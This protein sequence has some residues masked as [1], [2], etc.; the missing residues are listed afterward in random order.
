MLNIF[1]K[2]HIKSNNL[3]EKVEDIKATKT[4]KLDEIVIQVSEDQF[5]QVCNIIPN[6][7]N[8]NKNRPPDS[9]RIADIKEYYIRENIA[10]IP[11]IIYAWEK[12]NHVNSPLEIYDGIHRLLAAKELVHS[13]N[14]KFTFLLNI[15]KTENEEIIIRDFKSINK[16]CPVPVLYTE[17]NDQL[18]LIRRVVCENIV[19]ELC[20]KYPNFVSPSR[21][22]FRYNFNRDVVLEFLSELNINWNIEGL[23]GI[24]LQELYGLNFVAKDFV[25]RTNIQTPKKCQ[26]H[27]FYL[28]FLEKDF[29]KQRLENSI[30]KYN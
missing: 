1:K 29:I 15:T 20:N 19:S 17:T 11:G 9:I 21:K 2:T 27:N 14:K 16:S 13:H 6:F 26:F 24:I 3:Q 28:W 8:W 22:P 23:S 5:I 10:V 25:S 12:K 18:N 7:I 4:E 30:T